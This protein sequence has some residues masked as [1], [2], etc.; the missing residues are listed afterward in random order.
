MAFICPKCKFYSFNNLHSYRNHTNKCSF[1]TLTKKRHNDSN[2]KSI[3]NNNKKITLEST[4]TFGNNSVIFQEEEDDTSSDNNINDNDQFYNQEQHHP[5][6]DSQHLDIPFD[7]DFHDNHFS[8]HVDNQDIFQLRYINW[9]MRLGEIIYSGHEHH[10]DISSLSPGTPYLSSPNFS[11][12]STASTGLASVVKLGRVKD[13]NGL[14]YGIPDVNDVIDIF[15]YAKL[16][17]MSESA[18]DGLLQLLK[19]ILRRHSES[20]G[21]YF[22]YDRIEN[23]NLAITKAISNIYEGINVKI[24]LPLRLCGADDEE[25]NNIK[26]ILDFRNRD[27]SEFV[28]AKGNGLNVVQLIAEYLINIDVLHLDKVILVYYYFLYILY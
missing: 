3:G 27:L 9:Q 13:I 15:T 8:N 28:I 24:T 10:D 7:E 20:I 1:T 16:N 23:L 22:L 18:G 21:K 12:N 26:R 4:N 6:D 2:F 19:D 5:N 14:F 11:M 17:L 25:K